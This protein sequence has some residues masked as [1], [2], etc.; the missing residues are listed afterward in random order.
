LDQWTPPYLCSQ[1]EGCPLVKICSGS[2]ITPIVVY[3]TK[4]TSVVVCGVLP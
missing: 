4:Y 3:N 2:K 1:R